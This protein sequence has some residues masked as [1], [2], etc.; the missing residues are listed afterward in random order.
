MKK[1]ETKHR[2]YA[3][4][5]MT[6]AEYGLWDQCR[7]L[8]HKSGVLFFDGRKM[9]NRF[10]K[11]R[12]SGFMTVYRLRDSLVLGGWLVKIENPQPRRKNGTYTPTQYRALSHEQWVEKHGKHGCSKGWLGTLEE[13]QPVTPALEVP[14]TPALQ[15]KNQPV[16]KNGVACNKTTDQPVTPALHSLVKPES[17]CKRESQA[18]LGLLPN[19]PSLLNKEQD[20]ER[21]AEISSGRP[22]VPPVTSALQAAQRTIP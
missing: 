4:H 6:P 18:N 12:G 19:S 8:A 16:T 21:K 20:S 15:V 7:A 22:N 5:H 1:T 14:V 13:S 3:Q 2:C 11:E 9:A 17:T 10:K